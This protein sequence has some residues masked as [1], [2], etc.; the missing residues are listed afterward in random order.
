M[1]WRKFLTS[2]HRLMSTVASST[3]EKAV[4]SQLEQVCAESG[5]K[6]YGVANEI[7]KLQKDASELIDLTGGG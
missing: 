6:L 4:Q 3:V 5:H 1:I 7:I 2:C